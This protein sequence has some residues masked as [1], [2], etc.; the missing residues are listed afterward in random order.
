MLTYYTKPEKIRGT[1][2]GIKGTKDSCE[3]RRR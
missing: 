2:M 3:K 1:Q